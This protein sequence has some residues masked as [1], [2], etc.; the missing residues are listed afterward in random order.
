MLIALGLLTICILPLFAS[1][2]IYVFSAAW[3]TES[4]MTASGQ[5]PYRDF[6]WQYP[7]L[8]IFGPAFVV[9]LFGESM[10]TFYL[11]TTSLGFAT[12][13]V[14]YKICRLQGFGAITSLLWAFGIAGASNMATS[15]LIGSVGAY[16]PSWPIG[17]FGIVLI[18]WGV[19][20]VAIR[21]KKS[22]GALITTGVAI[23]LLSKQ[24]FAVAA[25]VPFLLL[26]TFSL[27]SRNSFRTES[28]TNTL[29][30]FAGGG[31]ALAMLAYLAVTLFT[32]FKPLLEGLGGY[33]QGIVFPPDYGPAA[34]ELL[35]SLAGTTAIVAL[36]VIGTNVYRSIGPRS[37]ML[38]A[39][40][41]TTLILLISF[42]AELISRN[43]I[44]LGTAAYVVAVLT[45]LGMVNAIRSRATVNASIRSTY[46][47]AFA[48]VG[49]T[50]LYE[51]VTGLGD[52]HEILLLP[53]QS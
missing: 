23:A 51:S 43:Q 3:F 4:G 20:V 50:V 36:L 47:A 32:G 40:T 19:S 17:F 26:V 2:P 13:F 16:T 14:I 29:L 25:I 28:I 33:G 9:W 8:G 15:R 34:V 46:L 12:V 31:I 24:E 21:P 38:I 45:I 11:L 39:A 7:P 35:R 5:M 44:I 41:L 10:T 49:A 6:T 48:L 1:V 52:D 22:G 27:L 18:A 53:R 37:L 42:A 30:K